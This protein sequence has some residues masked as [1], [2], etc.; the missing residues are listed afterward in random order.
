MTQAKAIGIIGAGICGL[1]AARELTKNGYEVWLL[2]QSPEVGGRMATHRVG[3][4][5]FDSG[6][7]FFTGRS[8]AFCD[9]I[10]QMQHAQVV[11]E[12]FRGYPSQTIRK[13]ESYPRFCGLSGMTDVPKFLVDN[14]TINLNENVRRVDWFNNHWR[15]TTGVSANVFWCDG[16]ILTPPVPQSLAFFKG[17]FQL[18]GAAQRALQKIN[19]EPCWAVLVQLDGPSQI[20]PPGALHIENGPISWIADNYQKGISP[21]PRSVTIHANG[22][23]TQQHF[24]ESQEAIIALL[25]E[26]ARDYLGANAVKSE[27]HL[28]RYA[29]PLTTHPAPCLTLNK[30]APLVFAGD[31]FVSPG[32]G[33]RVEGAALSGLA[34]TRSLCNLYNK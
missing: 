33:P 16:L 4:T 26:A 2:E 11:R 15:V 25:L 27:A 24:D 1:M 30:P 3:E 14:L 8:A 21:S 32:A 34:A 17:S 6:A 20:P 10:E 22:E 5:V 28:W 19:Y 18:P 7:Q 12:W 29:K 13:D 9:L 23:W 31:A